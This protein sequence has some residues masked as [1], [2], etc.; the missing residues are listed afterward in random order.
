[1]KFKFEPYENGY[2]VK[3]WDNVGRLIH[4]GSHK[5]PSG[6]WDQQKFMDQLMRHGY[7]GSLETGF[8]AKKRL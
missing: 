4:K 3:V 2:T 1:M 5:Y 6:D 8:W 7:I